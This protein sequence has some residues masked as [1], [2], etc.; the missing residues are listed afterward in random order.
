MDVTPLVHGYRSGVSTDRTPEDE[1]RDVAGVRVPRERLT[2][3]VERYLDGLERLE[4]ARVA[5]AGVVGQ[6]LHDGLV[7]AIE[8]VAAGVPVSELLPKVDLER[9]K[10]L[11]AILTEMSA[12]LAEARVGALRV[13]VDD[14]GT[15]LTEAARMLGIPRQVASRLYHG[16]E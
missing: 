14:E 4:F 12:A 3:A 15:T 8:A 7:G 6:S 9:R 16:R 1:G 2:P 13:L 11:I 10:V 5:V